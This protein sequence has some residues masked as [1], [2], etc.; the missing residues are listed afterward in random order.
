M[1]L[2]HLKALNSCSV[3][4]PSLKDFEHYHTSMWNKCNCALIWTFLVLPFFDIEMK[5]DLSQSC[6]H[7]W[8]FQIFWHIEC[9]I[10]TASSFRIC[11]LRPTWLHTLGCLA[12]V[13]DLT[14]I[15]DG[16]I[17][18]LM[19]IWIIKIFFV[20]FL[21]VFLPPLLNLF[22]YVLVIS[23]LY[24]DHFC[25]KCILNISNFLEEFLPPYFWVLKF[26][27]EK[28]SNC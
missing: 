6:G 16:A 25:M 18:L 11:F 21:C 12:Q 4:K 7:C 13:S 9:S 5:T 14:I 19:V 8:I 24:C 23:V 26:Q 1:Q 27:L 15:T 10:F 3:L 2:V 22:C 28:H 17:K 20:Q